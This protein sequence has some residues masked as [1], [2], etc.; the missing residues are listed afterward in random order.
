[1]GQREV[2]L[3]AFRLRALAGAGGTQQYEIR[4]NH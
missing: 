1:V 2:G 4:F 3:Q